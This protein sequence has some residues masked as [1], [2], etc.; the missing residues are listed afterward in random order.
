[1]KHITI[2]GCTSTAL[3]ELSAFDRALCKMG[4]GNANLIHLSSVIPKN[5]SVKITDDKHEFDQDFQGDRLYVV[6]AEN[7]TSKTGNTV[8]SGL[9][10]VTTNAGEPWGLFVEHIGET[11]DEVRDLI[12]KSLM[13]MMSDRTDYEWGDIQSKT[14]SITCTDEPVCALV[15]ATYKKEDW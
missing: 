3:T 2:R 9:G 8:A 14:V 4:L 12:H 6:Y 7:R 11:E 5:F 10:W 13:S 15:L 1:M